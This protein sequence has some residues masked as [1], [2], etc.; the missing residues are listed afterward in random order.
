[1]KSVRN[2]ASFLLLV[3]LTCAAG[4]ADLPTAK[5]E[6]VGMSTQ[7]LGKLK[8]EMQALVDRNQLPGVVTMVAKDG[9]V[10]EFDVAGKRDVESGAPLQKDSIFRIYSMSKPITGVA[11]MLLFEEGK[12]QLNDPVSKHIPE[13]ANLKVAKVNPQNGSVT[14]VAPDHPMTMRELMSHSG[15]LT[16]GVFGSTAVDKMYTDVNVLDRDA[17]LQAMIDKLG[18]I[19]LLHQPGERWHYSV[20]VDVQG[21]LVEKLSGQ[22]F[23]EFLK[24]RIFEPLGMKDTAFYVPADKMNRFVSFYTYDKDR[25]F[26]AHPGVPDFSKPPGAPSGGGGMVSTAMD[27]MRFCQ[28]LL[29][30]GELDGH[31][32]L[33]PLSVQ[34]MRSNVL[35]ASARTMGP[36]TGFGLDF[37]VVEDP[38]AAGGYGGEGTFYWGGYAGTWFW[39]D[40][41][42]NMIVVGMIQ[43]RG[44]GSPDVRGLSRN[45]T[46][47]A[48]VK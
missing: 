40:P 28:M 34:L 47:Q 1:M 20:S 36:G 32:L 18:K 48:I 2:F 37:A 27:Y 17:T 25:K 46:Y 13:F 31:R 21:Y 22:P 38:V 4:A 19:P 8:S 26:V 9:K 44:D 33:S 15:G 43:I 6:S 23:P 39:I 30:G 24:Q 35:P 45:L 11:M 7:R 14:Q 16:Y 29:N 3:L 41:V 10:V 12:W 5:P 42:Y